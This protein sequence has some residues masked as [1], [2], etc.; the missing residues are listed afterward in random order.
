MK[1][2]EISINRPVLACMMS[3][4]LVVFGLIGLNRLPVR[5]LPDVDPPIVNVQTI[6]RG[7]SAAVM[8]TQ[9]TEPLED[10]LM[11][12]EGIRTMTSESREQVS[13]ITIEFNLARDI[14]VVAQD[15]RDRVSRV[16]GRLPD[17][18]DE[19]IVAKQDAD[20]NPVLWVALF[21][22]RYSTL[23]LSTMAENLFKDRLQTVN[24]V[25][26]V[27][28]GGQ[29][30]FAIRLWLD[31]SKM[32]A[33]GVT[34]LDVENALK[35]ENVELP[36]GEIENWQRSL[37]I[38][39][40]GQMKNPDEYNRMVVKRDGD[41]LTRLG[42]IGNA[43]VGVEDERSIARFNSKPAV[44]IGV[45]KQS[46]ANTIEVV[47]HIKEEVARIMPSLP[48]GVTT[49]FPY[50]ESIYVEKSIVEVWETLAIA[51]FLVVITI[52]LFLYN[53]R[54][55]FIPAITIPVSII[56][57]FGVLYAFGYS[58][59][60]V[61][62]LGFVLAIGLVV[63]DA[64]I[65][66]ENIYRHIE[67]GMKPFDAAIQGMKEIGFVVI[68][69]TIALVAVFLPMAFQ[70]SV[71]G[72]LFIEFAVAISFS[73]IISAF[74]ALSLAPMLA[75]RILKPVDHSRKQSGFIA[76]LD[77]F[78]NGLTK[79]YSHALDW[80]LR[81]TK[82]IGVVCLIAVG[83]IVFFYT[84]LD[85]EFVP[86]ED[87]GRF[88]VFAIT[89]EGS[90]SEYT[91]RMVQKMEKIV[92]ATPETKEY[93]SAVALARGTPGNPSQGLAFIRLKED[94]PRRNLRDIIGGMQGL[95]AQFFSQIQGAFVIP[96][97]P[98]SFGGGF[99]QPFQLVIQSQ[100]LIA[101]N[102]YAEELTNKLRGLGFLM[103]V[104]STFEL[105]KPQLDLTIDRDRAAVLGVTVEDIA[106][107][108]QIAFGGS[109][110]SRVNINGKEYKV[111][112]Q[113]ERSERLTPTELDKLYVK[114]SSGQLVQ[115]SNLLTHDT[116]AGPSAINHHNRLRSAVI[117]A[118]P[119]GLPLGAVMEKVAAVLKDD[120]PV[121]FSYEWKGDAKELV[122]SS[123]GIYFILILAVIII[124]MVLASQF[125]SLIHPLTVM[126]TL[127]MAALGAFGGLWL[128]SLLKVPS[129]GINLYSQIGLIL[130]FG[131]V[132]KNAILLVEFANQQM[133]QGK[134]A[135]DAMKSAGV[136]RLRPILMTAAATIAGILPIAIGFGASGE[137][138][139]PLGVAAVSGMAV[140]TF[141][142]LFIIPVVYVFFSKLTARKIV[143]PS[144]MLM[145]LALSGLFIF[146]GCASVGSTY[147]RPK[148]DLPKAWKEA[149]EA[150][151]KKLG[152]DW[153]KAFGDSQLN[154]FQEQA[155]ANNQDI[156]GALANVE[157][158]R[159]L[160]RL[161]KADLSPK[162][163][164][165]AEAHR[166][167]FSKNITTSANK[168]TQNKFTVPLDFSYE[169]DIF[170]KVRRAYE[171]G[172]YASLAEDAA[173][174]TARLTL[175]A[176][177]AQQYFLIRQMD[178]EIDVLNQ[179]VYLRQ[180]I[181]DILEERGQ[182]GLT[183]QLDVSRGKTE[184]ARAQAQVIESRGR[185]AQYVNALSLL[186]GQPASDFTVAVVTDKVL[187]PPQV[188][189]GLPS[190]LLKRRP[191]I[192]EA[193]NL[194]AAANAQ[195][196]V[197]QGELFPSITL[198]GSAG[199]ASLKAESLFDWESRTASLGPSITLPFFDGGRN[200]AKLAAARA[201]YSKSIADYKGRVLTAIR[202]MEDALSNVR[203]QN[204]VYLAQQR[205]LDAAAN[206]FTLS[207][208]RY[209][210]GL[211]SY[212][213][214]V[215]S[216][217]S[218]LDAQ[219]ELNDSQTQR[220]IAA[221]ILVK[222]TGGSW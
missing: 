164:V 105:N 177:V 64:I 212:L 68:A 119:M 92:A 76:A 63:D 10:A 218:H 130:L 38:Q 142:T 19:P 154:Q 157:K 203:L 156:Q 56:A 122:D 13:S 50:D 12:V 29:K 1:L 27:I 69:T 26:S 103:N 207:Q 14:E 52:F 158:A 80:S 149:V 54:S 180:R 174:Q 16:R 95:G 188:P 195:I 94:A 40:Y 131:L 72:R 215:D 161:N 28:F 55:T 134:T 148:I 111:I 77:G 102:K 96:I 20:A 115:L 163:G 137:A 5:E 125:E 70:T 112:V 205:L 124:F 113:L 108:L 118:T 189:A 145:I 23:E 25:S 107:T 136:I 160:A 155:L 168:L 83:L 85:Q 39:T 33:R 167:K 36:S 62:M 59:N 109:D 86:L 183:S 71:T 49:S 48:Q 209:K 88:L 82:T 199:F 204:E 75:A 198:T 210:Q 208:D 133:A 60:I 66:L 201:A 197:A 98:R 89:P 170:G 187:I 73:V 220:L 104:R 78:F 184:L 97:I 162:A 159:A 53:F 4:G 173:F 216:Q 178:Q 128:M 123:Q 152:Q 24:G 166:E 101:L 91:D 196:G 81:H 135:I 121:G 57:T 42:D 193:E 100:D 171:A 202:E 99:T 194:L 22:D 211:V 65:V 146:Q 144:S 127:P 191:D 110:L 192:V 3:L 87:K 9:V 8:E 117:E 186:C 31:A 214:V 74:V 32:A 18:I 116:S 139:R 153:W 44:G 17:D 132:T 114:S 43:V 120:L 84:R 181:A 185:R 61:T 200:K 213:E 21:S 172:A 45:I 15:V 51:F 175:T 2:S 143:K 217:R 138:R 182:A 79:N 67:A 7:A 34:V 6:Y 126:V 90:T 221:V 165:N 37:S 47:K 11:S 129:M 58:I 176:E 30:R 150:D 93:F 190:D 46:K 141:L 219:I 222:A 179:A 106:K 140:S 35:K 41:S 147:A 206:T 169:L 151:R